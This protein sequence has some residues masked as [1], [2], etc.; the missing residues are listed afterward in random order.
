MRF[1][2][3]N[4]NNKNSSY[5]QATDET[6][7]MIPSPIQLHRRDPRDARRRHGR[8][9]YRKK[10]HNINKARYVVKTVKKPERK[11]Q[12]PVEVPPQPRPASPLPEMETFDIQDLHSLLTCDNKK[13][14]GK[15][16]DS[17]L[18][19][20]GEGPAPPMTRKCPWMECLDTCCRLSHHG[21]LKRKP[22]D[23]AMRRRWER[24]SPEEKAMKR[25]EAGGKP[26]KP[27]NMEYQACKKSLLDC[28]NPSHGHRVIDLMRAGLDDSKMEVATSVTNKSPHTGPLASETPVVVTMT[29]SSLCSTV[30]C[31]TST[32]TTSALG[33]PVDYD[34]PQ[35]I[36]DHKQ[37]PRQD[38][39]VIPVP[40]GKT[41][42]GD[43]KEAT[44]E[45]GTGCVSPVCLEIGD[46][47]RQWDVHLPLDDPH[48]GETS[49][50][51]LFFHVDE[52]DLM[53]ETSCLEKVQ[54][55]IRGM[56]P[57]SL[58][59]AHQDLVDS[60][61]A[62][63]QQ[64][65]VLG[66]SKGKAA[67]DMLHRVGYNRSRRARIFTD[68]A[69]LL[70]RDHTAA[71]G[72][73]LDGKTNIA[74]RSYVAASKNNI[75]RKVVKKSCP[76]HPYLHPR[77]AQIVRN[78]EIYANNYLYIES[79]RLAMSV[80]GNRKENVPVFRH[81]GYQVLFALPFGLVP[82]ASLAL[83]ARYRNRR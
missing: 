9:Q 12:A 22:L 1:L 66:G 28:D 73:C 6:G 43:T 5:L 42:I 15:K 18:G 35:E 10:K 8:P 48:F 44:L 55:A 67:V 30:T 58:Q 63:H 41:V 74:L 77:Y 14:C 61:S 57:S 37:E 39:V 38:V 46:D 25:R 7:L 13:H 51:D 79:E 71:R 11:K 59:N 54:Q 78:T 40:E 23:A 65:N 70:Y 80:P 29:N 68:L 82:T 75:L 33:E 26:M 32:L 24:M 56:L 34:E 60:T 49:V 53:D 52:K 31:L 2:L 16:F 45:D 36:K 20:P 21:H 72:Q 47:G 81:V 27:E 83:I 76:H 50:V 17:T 4:N 3:A 19:Y 62:T 69:P 64:V